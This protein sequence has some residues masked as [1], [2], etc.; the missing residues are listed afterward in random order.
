MDQMIRQVTSAAAWLLCVVIIVLSDVPPGMRPVVGSHVVEHVVAYA[1]LGALFGLTYPERAAGCAARL[2]MFCGMIEVVQVWVP[3]R[4][5]RLM[6]F[7]VDATASL[8][9]LALAILIGNFGRKLIWAEPE[10]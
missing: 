10:K 2:V 7:A 3:G 8:S 4:H 9:G 5:A 1:M 6:D